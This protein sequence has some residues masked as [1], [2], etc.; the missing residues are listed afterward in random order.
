MRFVLRFAP[1]LLLV[2]CAA[3]PAPPVSAPPPAA[4]PPTTTLA[5]PPPAPPRVS[6]LRGRVL[7]HDKKPLPLAHAHLGERVVE[8]DASGAFT[9]SDIPPGLAQLRFTG[10]NHAEHT[11]AVFFDG[12][13]VELEVTLGT[14]ERHGPDLKEARAIVRVKGKEGAPTRAIGSPH[15]VLQLDKTYL[16]VVDNPGDKPAQELYC[17]LDS[18]ARDRQ[19]AGPSQ[20]GYAYAGNGI[21]HARLP[22]GGKRK[23]VIRLSPA[24]IPPPGRRAS[25]TFSDPKSRAARISALWAEAED[26]MSE[27]PERRKEHAA[28]RAEMASALDRED[29][30][31]V[32][33]ALRIAYLTPESTLDRADEQ[34]SKIARALRDSLPPAAPIWAFRPEAA[35]TASALSGRDAGDAWLDEIGDK[36]LPRDTAARFFAARV[37]SASLGGKDEELARLQTLLKDRFD[38]SPARQSVSL[39]AASRNVRPGR[40]IPDFDLPLLPAPGAPRGARITRASLQGKVVLIDFWGT[41]CMPCIKEMRGL[42][43]A[44]ERHQARGFS[45]LSIAKD[46]ATSVKNFRRTQWK[47]PWDH[48][49]LEDESRE[50]AIAAFEVKSY[51]SPILVGRDGKI[52]A[53]GDDLR[54]DALRRAVDLAME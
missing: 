25:V 9:L 6:S 43:A 46:K 1:L 47:M 40:A 41:W 13:D 20:G 54:G 26:R 12:K 52:L 18:V 17:S 27:G 23:L 7:G 39:Y 11:A 44:F 21:Y 53:I 35:I 24:D 15:F 29:D 30:I 22:T 48:V 31:E 49:I 19:I 50:E 33:S 51:P 8:C 10:V 42:H 3:P 45:I 37:R 28:K 36:L 2:A 32:A 5:P 38:D 14:H 16:A 4:P 34:A